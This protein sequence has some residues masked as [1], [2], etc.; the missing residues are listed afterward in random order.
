MKGLVK[1]CQCLKFWCNATNQHG[2]HSP[3]VFN[4]TTN[5]LYD[6]TPLEAYELLTE[7]KKNTN[8][9][10]KLL[11]KIL[12]Y[13]QF[14]K[15]ESFEGICP[16]TKSILKTNHKPLKQQAQFPLK[17]LF[18]FDQ[19][20]S[21]NMQR[22]FKLAATASSDVVVFVGNIRASDVTYKNWL[23]LVNKP[24]IKVSIDIYYVGL[25]VFRKE[26]AKEHFCIR[27]K[28]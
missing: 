12:S 27:P 18:Y 16:T 7:P 25:L 23:S 15:I 11:I 14:Q 22:I 24:I 6:K 26:Q 5:C 19:L 4:L 21:D 2:I 1:I 20:E 3:F 17:Q 10:L 9:S 28:F 13:Y 8:K